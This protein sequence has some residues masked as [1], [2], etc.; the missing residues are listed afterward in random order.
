M[1][2]TLKIY[3]GKKAFDIVSVRKFDY[4][5]NPNNLSESDK[6][7]Y[8]LNKLINQAYIDCKNGIY[9]PIVFNDFI[10][11]IDEAVDISPYIY[12]I[13]SVGVPVYYFADNALS[14]ER[15]LSCEAN[16]TVNKD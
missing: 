2:T 13:M 15:L 10:S 5:R 12:K 1:K 8:N 11:H 9:L 3:I 16:I 4:S 7:L 14:L 6:I